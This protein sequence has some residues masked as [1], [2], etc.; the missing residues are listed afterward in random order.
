MEVET[1]EVIET[2]SAGVECDAEAI[3]LIE[4]LGLTGQQEL[5]TAPEGT[6]TRNPYRLMTREELHVYKIL[7]PKES[8]IEAY[9]DG[10]IPLRVLQVAAHAK[11]MFDWLTVCCP[12]TGPKDNPI[13]IGVKAHATHRSL[14]KERFILA[15]WGDCL[16]PFEKM[17]EKAAAI[18]REGVIAA[19]NKVRAEVAATIAGLEGMGDTRALEMANDMPSFFARR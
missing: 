8:R 1:Y 15:R 3:K 4:A 17:K 2:T 5:V 16:L 13:L 19:M 6:P 14:E 9:S 18:A 11:D 12:A 7:M 10:P